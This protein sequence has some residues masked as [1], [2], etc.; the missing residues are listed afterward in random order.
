MYKE[1]FKKHTF[2]STWRIYVAHER[3]HVIVHL[4]CL[5]EI[6]N[7]L[8]S[9][10]DIGISGFRCRPFVTTCTCYN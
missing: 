3:I 5:N 1:L 6:P 4:T 7:I 2:S 10:G 9:C 8:Q